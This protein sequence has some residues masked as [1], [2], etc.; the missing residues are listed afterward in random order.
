MDT[1][2]I[3]AIIVYGLLGVAGLFVLITA[4]G[5][6]FSVTSQ[7]VAIVERFGKYV[8][9][10]Q[11]GLNWKKPFIESVVKELNLKVM[12]D[13]IGVDTITK[14][15]VSVRVNV[16]VQY[17]IL[18][19]R[20]SDAYYKLYNPSKQIESYVFDVVRSMVTNETLDEVFNNKNSIAA[21]VKQE[22]ATDMAAFG[23]EINRAL[24]TEIE[25]DAKVKSAMNDINT[26]KREQEAATA[27]GE[28]AKTIQ[29]KA[30][31]AQAEADRLRG[32]GLAD[33][34]MEIVSGLR[35]SIEDLQHAIPGSSNEEVMTMLLMTQYLETMEKIGA[36]SK[37]SVLM[38]PHSPGGMTSFKDEIMQGVLAASA[39]VNGK[40][41]SGE[42]KAANQA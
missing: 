42:I 22:L 18:Q 36:Q 39:S 1:A 9:T 30:A 7:T 14:D 20:E 33:Q 26:A 21:A 10:A 41:V 3:H 19:G 35:K 13:V 40:P 27:R 11:P 23:Y 5:S 37:S 2:L 16:A 28:A 6:F 32:K 38:I 29:I 17:N 15:K 25:P 12:Q 8:R 31:E 34:R 4:L 24:V